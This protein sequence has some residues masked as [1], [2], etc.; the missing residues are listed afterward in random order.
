MPKQSQ[1]PKV[2]PVSPLHG[3]KQVPLQTMLNHMSQASGMNQKQASSKVL[4]MQLGPIRS[5]VDR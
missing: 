3:A 4:E 5:T 2:K 1:T